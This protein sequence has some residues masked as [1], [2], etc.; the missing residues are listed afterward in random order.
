MFVQARRKKTPPHHTPTSHTRQATTT[1][2]KN[3]KQ[4]ALDVGRH[5]RLG[6][7][8]LAA[9][10]RLPLFAA[11]G[12]EEAGLGCVCVFL[13]VVLL[14]DMPGLSRWC[15]ALRVSSPHAPNKQDNPPQQKD[16][17]APPLNSQTQRSQV[18]Q[19]TALVVAR[20]GLLEQAIHLEHVV[21]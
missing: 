6:A 10:P 14:G 5:R 7:H 21:P 3:Q 20:F 19:R 13:V 12:V 16:N 4:N 1:T 2:T 17:T 11:D 8:A 18:N 9:R 15:V